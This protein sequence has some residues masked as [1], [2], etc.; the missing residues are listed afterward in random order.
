MKKIIFVSLFALALVGCNE[1]SAPEVTDTK[2]IVI[3]GKT[4]KPREYLEAFCRE[5]N[6]PA[7]KNCM[8]VDKQRIV[9]MSKI[10]DVKL[11]D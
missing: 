9:D 7:D 2:N 11:A 6:S 8:A 5:A 1:K 4:Y 3:D 10:R